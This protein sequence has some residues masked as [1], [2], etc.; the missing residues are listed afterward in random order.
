MNSLI[1]MR[2][3]KKKVTLDRK[4]GPRQALLMNLAESLIL[5]EHI[6]TTNAKAKV[7][8]TQVERL[9]TKA[10][11]NT[12]AAR[13]GLLKVLST[14]TA[15]K[16]L[17]EVLGPRF[18]ERQGGYTRVIRLGNRKGDGADESVVEFV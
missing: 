15:V 10:K 6:K 13:R 1:H 12:L 2:H 5:Y 4:T 18:A 14:P 7:T 8:R 3:Y 16:K 9:I 17:M 11:K